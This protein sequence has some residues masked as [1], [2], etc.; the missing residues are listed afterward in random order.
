MKVAGPVTQNI[1]LSAYG[2]NAE[3][4]G[5]TEA[6]VMGNQ[7]NRQVIRYSYFEPDVP[8]AA[9]LANEGGAGGK[10]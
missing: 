4:E 5:C 9:G 3:A 8:G 2:R 7:R 6:F 10:K 1:S